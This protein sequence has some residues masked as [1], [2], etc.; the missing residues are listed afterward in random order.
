MYVVVRMC[1]CMPLR[2]VSIHL[3][4]Q[5]FWEASGLIPPRSVFTALTMPQNP[6]II[7]N[8]C[9]FRLDSV[10]KLPEFGHHNL[11][12]QIA[13][14]TVVVFFAP[15]PDVSE[16]LGTNVQKHLETH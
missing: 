15:N 7:I 2:D 6:K 10:V 11:V 8:F 14:G 1:V 3:H 4:S 5:C 9:N 13:M 16:M 12:P